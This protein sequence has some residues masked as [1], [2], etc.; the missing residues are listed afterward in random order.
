[1]KK[2]GIFKWI[3]IFTLFMFI[4]PECNNYKNET[5]S[6]SRLLK[7]A[8]DPLVQD[9]YDYTINLAN[10]RYDQ[11]MSHPKM[12]AAYEAFIAGQAFLPI[13]EMKTDELQDKELIQLIRNECQASEKRKV[14]HEKYPDI[15]KDREKLI[16]MLQLMNSQRKTSIKQTSKFRQ[17]D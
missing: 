9:S 2:L 12:R 8:Q 17:H 6:H 10:S 14:V 11:F 7:A 5:V 3:L 16:S 15:F 13:C 4:L 1:M